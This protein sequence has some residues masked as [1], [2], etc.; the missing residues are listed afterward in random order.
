MSLISSKQLDLNASHFSNDDRPLNLAADAVDYSIYGMKWIDLTISAASFTEVGGNSEYDLVDEA[1]VDAKII[2]SSTLYRNGVAIKRVAGTP[3]ATDEWKLEA[4]KIIVYSDVSVTAPGDSY[5]L[6]YQTLSSGSTVAQTSE[7]R[8]TYLLERAISGNIA[9]GTAGS[10]L[11]IGGAAPDGSNTILLVNNQT[12]GI[13][14]KLVGRRTD[15][16]GE[17][18]YFE[19]SGA[20][21]RNANAA[22]TSIIGSQLQV[23]VANDNA[24]DWDARIVADTTN[25]GIFI[26]IAQTNSAAKSVSWKAFAELIKIS[27]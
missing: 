24:S 5:H 12:V 2:D 25:G 18:A 26:E 21:E 23:I 20:F 7:G 15:A 19:L 3:S 27:E 4:G 10:R 11:T 8:S 13:K 9:F 14:V 17:G 1:I 16:D 6:E 22:S